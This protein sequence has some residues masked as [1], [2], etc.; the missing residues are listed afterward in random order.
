MA[1]QSRGQV[2]DERP[3]DLEKMGVEASVARAWLAEQ[4]GDDEGD[5]EDLDSPLEIWPQNW[6][7]LRAW[8]AMRESDT[9]EQPPS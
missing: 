9:E 5:S 4:D 3:D 8:L 1:E 6:P 2:D 7:A